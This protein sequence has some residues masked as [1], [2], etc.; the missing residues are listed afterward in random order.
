MPELAIRA[1]AVS[2]VPVNDAPT[3]SATA[4]DPTFVEN[5]APVGVYSGASIGLTEAADR[6]QS[7]TLTVA[8]LQNGSDE[9][10]VVDGTSVVLS[11]G[12]MASYF[13]PARNRCSARLVLGV[14]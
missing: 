12:N 8:G 11:D 10:L 1:I 13:Y 7:M 3:L 9:W 2:M 4:D 14:F 6:V 5:K